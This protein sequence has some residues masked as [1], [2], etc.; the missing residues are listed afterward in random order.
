[1]L[2]DKSLSNP[3]LEVA[4]HMSA[5]DVADLLERTTWRLIDTDPRDGTPI[6]TWDVDPTTNPIGDWVIVRWQA[7]LARQ[8]GREEA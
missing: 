3:N 6:I 5:K 8:A 4:R 2:D 7:M 1:M